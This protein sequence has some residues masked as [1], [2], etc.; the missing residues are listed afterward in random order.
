M[1]SLLI[2]EIHLMLSAAEG[3]SCHCTLLIVTHSIT[4]TPIKI[5]HSLPT[6]QYSVF[7]TPLLY[8]LAK[9][10]SLLQAAMAAENCA[11]G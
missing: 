1:M 8:A 7:F 5:I 9:W 3:D 2:S 6:S 10:L 11:M 4:D